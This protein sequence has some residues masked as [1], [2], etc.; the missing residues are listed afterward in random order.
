[1]RGEFG[2]GSLLR[3]CRDKI[4][5]SPIFI[6]DFISAAAYVIATAYLFH[7][8][9]RTVHAIVEIGLIVVIVL[10]AQITKIVILVSLERR[11]GDARTFKRSHVLVTDGVY[12]YSRNPV[13]LAT[14]VQN[15]LWSLVLLYRI[16]DRHESMAMIAVLLIVPLAHFVSVNRFVVPTEEA[17]LLRLHP[18]T[19]PAYAHRVNRW[20]GRRS[21]SS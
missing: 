12:G 21:A 4:E 11:G 1:M 6:L 7:V 10:V 16:V 8:S 2:I 15:V 20:I 3:H 18:E 9:P 14:V 17:D 19:Y 5:F 13:Y